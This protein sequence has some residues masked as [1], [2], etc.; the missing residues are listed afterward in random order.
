MFGAMMEGIKEESVGNLFNLKVEVQENPIVEEAAANGSVSPGAPEALA[1]DT[2]EAASPPAAPAPGIPG[3][4]PAGAH[5]RGGT[6]ARGQRAQG[7]TARQGG[8][9]QRGGSAQQ[10]GTGDGTSGT[11]AG[12]A[13]AKSAADQ[14]AAVP[15]GLGPRRAQ[16]LEYSAPSVDGGT[17][18][19]T[20]RGT[21]AGDEY[22]RVGRNDPC[23]CGSGRKFK[24]CHGDPRNTP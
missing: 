16:R 20:S 4:R 18:V 12:G 6:P 9:A 2:P 14:E 11:R 21:A 24:R 17:H 5:A 23:P 8:T 10:V 1:I 3:P 19:E 22:S 7:G 13:H 15:A